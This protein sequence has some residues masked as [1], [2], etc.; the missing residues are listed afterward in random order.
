MMYLMWFGSGILQVNCLDLSEQK[1]RVHHKAD[2]KN[3]T[4]LLGV[5]YCAG[6]EEEISNIGF[7][8]LTILADLLEVINSA[9][10]VSKRLSKIFKEVESSELFQFI[11]GLSF[12]RLI[13]AYRI[14]ELKFGPICRKWDWGRRCWRKE[15]GNWMV[16][17][18]Y[19][20]SDGNYGNMWR[21]GEYWWSM[22][23]V[24]LIVSLG[25]ESWL[26][27]RTHIWK[28]RRN[29]TL[30]RRVGYLCWLGRVPTISVAKII[31]R[32]NDKSR[33]E[34]YHCYFSRKM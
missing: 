32:W 20:L 1:H 13:A 23:L 25:L 27:F 28:V 15:E 30:Q 7:I 21:K 2:M 10:T 12:H 31:Y 5:P 26:V 3:H 18:N 34:I 11:E 6:T 19:G 22:Q 24:V 9:A 8:L 33:R 29:S 4:Y 14:F 17:N 16:Q